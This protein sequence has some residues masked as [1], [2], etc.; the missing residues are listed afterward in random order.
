[1]YYGQLQ[2]CLLDNNGTHSAVYKS[3]LY[4]CTVLHTSGSGAPG[5]GVN[6]EG[7]NHTAVNTILG[8]AANKIP[9]LTNCAYSATARNS[10]TDFVDVNPAVGDLLI[11]SD[12]VPM[13]GSVAIDAGDVSYLPETLGDTD[14]A[15]GQRVYNGAMDIGCFEFDWRPKYAAILGKGLTVTAA[16]PEVYAVGESAVAV[17]GGSLEVEWTNANGG[18]RNFIGTM[19]V[20]GTGTL[21]AA[22]GGETFATVAETDGEQTFSFFSSSALEQLAFAYTPG[23]DDTGAALL[24]SFGASEGLTIIFR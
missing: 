13:E 7:S 20:T 16:S 24:S 3:K 19:R 9:S 11:G 6:N 10:Y 17:P 18:K 23:E 8:L 2:G 21:T 12:G 5:T 4:N 1:M 22:R 15:G 14:L